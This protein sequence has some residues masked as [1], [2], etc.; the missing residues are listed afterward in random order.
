MNR[1]I[2]IKSEP[3]WL[4]KAAEYFSSRFNIDKQLYLDSMNDSIAT[5][6]PIPRWYLLVSGTEIIGGFGLINNDFMVRTDL[7]PWLCALFVEPAHRGKGHGGEILDYACS[8]AKCLGFSKLYLNTDHIGYY[9]KYGWQY[10]G[11]F[12]H[13]SGENARVYVKE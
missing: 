13:A 5:S 2:N 3:E 11:D 10:M 12:A 6:N 7:T 9:E 4:E 8:E 1:Y